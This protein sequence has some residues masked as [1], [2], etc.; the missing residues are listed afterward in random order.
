MSQEVWW[1]RRGRR[2]RCKGI[3]K[4]S[5]KLRVASVCEYIKFS[6][7]PIT[8]TNMSD[9]LCAEKKA[10]KWWWSWYWCRVPYRVCFGISRGGRMTGIERTINTWCEGEILAS[11]HHR[12]RK[13]I[14]IFVYGIRVRGWVVEMM[15]SQRAGSGRLF[16]LAVAQKSMSPQF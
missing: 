14:Y 16:G 3:E 4:G 10:E 15:V 9:C 6:P 8:Q 12:K 2:S 11:P 7:T 5:V 13:Y 1:L